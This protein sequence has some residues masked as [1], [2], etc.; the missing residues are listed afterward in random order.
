MTSKSLLAEAFACHEAA[1]R[2]PTSG[3]TGGSTPA[4]TGKGFGGLSA[5]RDRRV[6]PKAKFKLPPTGQQMDAAGIPEFQTTKER[7]QAFVKTFFEFDL[8]EGH[9]SRL[10]SVRIQDGQAI[11]SGVITD[12]YGS[13]RGDF[14]RKIRDADGWYD[15]AK[16]EPSPYGPEHQNLKTFE[17]M[18]V[19]HTSFAMNESKQGSGIG[20]SFIAQSV[21]RYKEMGIDHV[22]VHAGDAVGGY[23]WAR[24]GFRVEDGTKNRNPFNTSGSDWM[25]R[26]EQI[27]KLADTASRKL[28]DL[29]ATGV[30]PMYD[31]KVARQDLAALR[32]ASAAG[33][34]VQPI[35]I[36]S[37]GEGDGHFRA[38]APS[39]DYY[40][41]WAGKEML[42]GASWQG[43]YY[44]DA[45]KAITAAAGLVCEH[46]SLTAACHDASC[47]PPTSG[48]TGG[49]VSRGGTSAPRVKTKGDAPS[50]TGVPKHNRTAFTAE[51][52]NMIRSTES[53]KSLG[54]EQIQEDIKTMNDAANERQRSREARG[55]IDNNI[56]SESHTYG[57]RHHEP[58]R[59]KQ[60][61]QMR[62]QV[63][64]A[65]NKMEKMAREPDFQPVNDGERLVYD[66]LKKH[67]ARQDISQDTTVVVDGLAVTLRGYNR[68]AVT[69][70]PVPVD[71][72][73]VAAVTRIGARINDE[74]NERMKS[75]EPTKS[76]EAYVG[77]MDAV[78]NIIREYFP[79]AT[80][81]DWAFV[82]FGN[83]GYVQTLGSGANGSAEMGRLQFDHPMKQKLKAYMEGKNLAPTIDFQIERDRDTHFQRMALEVMSEVRSMDG[84]FNNTPKKVK[85]KSGSMR[86][87]STHDQVVKGAQFYPTE[88][89][90]ASNANPRQVGFKQT[91]SRAHYQHTANKDGLATVTLD[92]SLPTT[93]HE[94]A[95]RM[96][97]TVPGV[98]ELESTFY[99]RRTQGESLKHLGKGYGAKELTREDKFYD[100]YVGKSYGDQAYE[101]LSMGTQQL[102]AKRT[103]DKIDS[104]YQ[105]F[106]LGTLA[107]AYWKE[108]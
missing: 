56:Y 75:F 80:H 65:M 89:I 73:V 45:S 105:G 28:D 44:F 40:D 38:Q 66:T 23:A 88:W 19:D 101:V 16:V 21:A 17:G 9:Q 12:K 61:T 5:P 14:E 39:G 10:T 49:S 90:D 86:A 37:L 104:D 33:E 107:T 62:E 64:T 51:I 24:E 52:A 22:T 74:I 92:G 6:A 29:E 2:P 8:P 83:D 68:T 18:S 32:V 67:L 26:H 78:T 15:A 99:D 57:W 50:A 25:S 106:I 79:L 97:R 108:G 41:S 35:H 13:M 53:L 84:T 20:S 77:H 72:A 82:S 94:M 103:W 30:I 60:H 71:D 27:D 54:A 87:F 95:H 63:R 36:A 3:G 48:G 31:L 4:R 1:C 91:K 93:I 70:P 58:E 96:E 34:D 100:P 98:L 11:V 47:R 69:K 81:N 85:P 42:L 59:Y 43:A 102:T 46:G 76:E 7:Q 55:S